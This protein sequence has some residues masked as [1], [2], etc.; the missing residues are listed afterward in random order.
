MTTMMRQQRRDADNGQQSRWQQRSRTHQRCDA[1]NG[2][3]LR[4]RCREADPTTLVDTC[5]E[6]MVE[7]VRIFWGL[8]EDKMGNVVWDGT[9]MVLK[10]YYFFQYT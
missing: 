2:Q 1:D 4:Q 5:K 6:D 10:Y 7:V 9:C 3:Q 8:K